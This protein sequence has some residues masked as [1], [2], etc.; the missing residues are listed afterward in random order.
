M[1]VLVTGGSGYFGSLLINKLLK[2]GFRVG[3]LDINEPDVIPTGVD[4]HKID[5]RDID[6]LKN[7]LSGYKIIFHNVAQVPLAKN[8]KLF[9]EV[10]VSGTKNICEASLVN[11]VDKIVYTSSSAIYGIPEKNPVNEETAPN[12]GEEYGKAKLEGEK[13]CERYSKKGI[14]VTIIRPRTILGHGRLGIFSILFKWV[15]DG[16]NIPVLNNGDNIYQFVHA[17]DLA[18]ACILAS[19]DNNLFSNYNIGAKNFGTMRETLESLCEYAG[20][21]SRVYSLPLRP[22]EILMNIFSTLRLSP[23]GP[24]HSLMYGR[25]LYFDISKAEEELGFSPKYNTIEMFRESY[26]WFINNVDSIKLDDKTSVHRKPVKEAILK[27]I[28]W[29]S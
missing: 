5:I 7:A 10:N 19:K 8:N 11:S 20:T 28:R 14:S 18:D 6:S 3:S 26:D 2:S 27:I 25:S 1:K 13:I 21:E 17:E 9:W 12:P 16:I 23:L 4:F 24:Y 29:V 15:R 22:I